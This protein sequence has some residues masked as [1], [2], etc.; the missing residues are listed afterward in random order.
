MR[1]RSFGLCA[2]IVVLNLG[3]WTFAVKPVSRPSGSA[4][5]PGSRA[6]RAEAPKSP[7][8][9]KSEESG[10]VGEYKT[11]YVVAILAL[12]LLGTVFNPFQ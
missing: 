4:S 5:E 10:L 8:T 3:L 1:G 11:E 12:V 6:G 7:E 9:S 2:L